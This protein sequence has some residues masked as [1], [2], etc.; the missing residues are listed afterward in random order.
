MLRYG[1]DKPDLRYG[2]EI[3]DLSD[4]AAQTE[5]KVFQ[6]AVSSGGKVRGLNAK[7]AADKFS[8]KGLDEL[9]QLV[10]RFGAKGLAW[11][12]VEAEKL[13]SPIEKFL[14]ASVQ[15][16]LRHRMAAEPGDLLLLVADKED[17]VCQALTN[18]RSHLATV[19]K[20]YDPSKPVYQI[21]WVIDLPVVPSGTP[22]TSAG[23]PII[24]RSRHRWMKT[25][26]NW[27]VIR[28]AFA[29]R[30]TTS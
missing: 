3:T 19:L 4:W 23:R 12:K 22:R 29:P 18:L 16:A 13:T 25:W 26:I 1:T 6:G 7:G 21:A 30:R 20:L 27:K 9:E 10:K 24:I 2:L 14:P 5:F 11:I 15:Q 8:R 28:A 17:V